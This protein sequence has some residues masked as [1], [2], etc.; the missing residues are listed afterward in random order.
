MPADFR[1][2]KTEIFL[3]EKKRKTGILTVLEAFCRF[4]GRK[5]VWQVRT[6]RFSEAPFSYKS[7][8]F[9]KTLAISEKLTDRT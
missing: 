4:Y 1:G 8:A 6:L 5:G 9:P 2:R 3:S 7:M